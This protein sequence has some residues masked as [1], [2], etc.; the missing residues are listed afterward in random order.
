MKKENLL[1]MLKMDDTHNYQL[2]A[3]IEKR[4]GVSW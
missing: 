1:K 4:I 2:L 3:V